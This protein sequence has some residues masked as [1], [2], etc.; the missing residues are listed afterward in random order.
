M[1]IANTIDKLFIHFKKLRIF[2]SCMLTLNRELLVSLVAP[3]S[4]VTG[5]FYRVGAALRA[6]HPPRGVKYKVDEK[7]VRVPP[8]F[9][10]YKPTPAAFL[11]WLWSALSDH[12]K[13]PEGE[14]IHSFFWS[15]FNL[16]QPWIHENDSSLSQ[17]LSGYFGF[18][19]NAYQ[20]V[21]K[22]ATSIL[23]A[24]SC[25]AVIVWSD[26]AKKSMVKDGVEEQKIEVVPPPMPPHERKQ[27]DEKELVLTFVGRD[28]ERKGGEFVLK[29]FK[30]L[31]EKGWQVRLKYIGPIEN[32]ALKQWAK[33]NCHIEYHEFMLNQ[34]LHAKVFPKTDLLLLP[35]KAEAYGITVLEAMSYGVPVLIT[36]LPVLREVTRV[37]HEAIYFERDNFEQF[38]ERLVCLLSDEKLRKTVGKAL[39]RVVE[40]RYHPEI[41]N[42]KLLRIY[43]K[44][45]N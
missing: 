37:S 14:L 31:R 6:Q 26:V 43:Q 11:Y 28:Y 42:Q 20:K 17:Y 41:V 40:E 36:D 38:F 33:N 9:E 3:K 13:K 35:T 8:R 30:A 29:A 1:T 25:K 2:P 16:W 45:L 34:E 39:K 4:A 24:K 12:L 19:K 5:G 18:N 15:Y 44:S 10:Q 22:I 23:N 21:L 27:D 32:P 7:L